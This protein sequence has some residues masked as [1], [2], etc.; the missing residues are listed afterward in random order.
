M[1]ATR[2]E[3]VALRKALAPLYPQARRRAWPASVATGARGR[4]TSASTMRHSL[5]TG[6]VPDRARGS[7][8]AS[9]QAG[10]HRDRRHLGL[11]GLLRPV[12]PPPRPRHQ[13]AV[14]QGA[15][16]RVHRR[17]RRGDAAFFERSTTRPRPSPRSTSRPTWSGWTAIPTTATPS[18]CSGSAGARRSRPKASVLLLGDARNNY[19]AAGAW[20]V[21]ELHHRARHVYWLNPEPRAYW[22]SGD[23]IV[24]E[25]AQYCDDVVECRTLRQLED[26]VGHLA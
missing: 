1:H 25:Y 11:G 26:F 17:H 18:R 6:G 13:L 7:A 21:E 19:H 20:V 15:Q 5:S 8:P 23:S 9:G 10:D 24:G 3:L 22:G 4:S 2:E 12:H 16:L 14:L